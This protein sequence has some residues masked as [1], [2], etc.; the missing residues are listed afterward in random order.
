MYAECAGVLQ[1]AKALLEPNS[2]QKRTRRA[3][4]TER[5]RKKAWVMDVVMCRGRKAGTRIITKTITTVECTI[6]PFVGCR[7]AG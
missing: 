5:R 2:L 6:C 3:R 4:R 1:I 7:C